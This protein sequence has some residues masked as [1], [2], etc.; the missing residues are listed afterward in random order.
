M[1]AHN[2]HQHNPQQ[3]APTVCSHELVQGSA[4]ASQQ[5]TLIV[6]L[7]PTAV[8]KTELSLGLCERF[9][10]EVVGADSRQI[11]RGMDIGTAK[12]TAAEMARVP[13]HLI[14]ICNP[15]EPFSL[16]D[17]QQ[18]AYTVIDAIHGRGHL[19]FLV[20][21]TALYI[22]AIVQG[23]RLPAVAPDPILR[24]RLETFLVEQGR[25]ALFQWLQAIDPA[26]AAVIDGKNP[27]RVLRALEIFLSTGQSK[28]V[29][30][31][32][33]PP[34]Y[35]ILLIGL[36]RSREVLYKRTDQR[37]AAMMAQ[38]LLDE[39]KRL[40]AA[41]YSPP[42]PAITSLGY[43]ELIDHLAG[44]LSLDAAVERIKH[45]T[46]RF[47]RHQYTSF[48]KLQGIIWIDL[49]QY[50]SASIYQLVEEFLRNEPEQRSEP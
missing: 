21:G 2:V 29:L 49:D 7:G 23:L 39:T 36:D 31:G 33:E 3:S 40:V 18:R 9:Q 30:E 41:G 14:D 16:A 28:V 46:H 20:G 44:N 37:I 24:A 43:R 27:R 34:P 26:T 8:G 19:P 6:L 50:H 11:Y 48:R 47:V 13:H 1:T 12:P 4:G 25:D 32:A 38:G 15:D 22:R 5:R 10:G 42:L 17:Y 35:R 45:E